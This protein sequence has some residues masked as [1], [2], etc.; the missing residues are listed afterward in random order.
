VDVD[1]ADRLDIFV[2]CVERFLSHHLERS[3][4]KILNNRIITRILLLLLQ[5]CMGFHGIGWGS[6]GSPPG[7]ESSYSGRLIGCVLVL[8]LYTLRAHWLNCLK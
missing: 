7:I 1:F 4:W 5:Y 3:L 2:L 6:G 8:Y